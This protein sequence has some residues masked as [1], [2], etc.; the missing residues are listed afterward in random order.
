MSEIHDHTDELNELLFAAE[1]KLAE[2]GLGVSA[3]VELTP[4]C[5]LGFRKR[6]EIWHLVV[7]HD[8]IDINKY[9]PLM[10]MPRQYRVL[11][12][13]KLADLRD[14]LIAEHD[15]W[16]MEVRNATAAAR[17]FVDSFKTSG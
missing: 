13:T 1:D 3:F 14:A 7:R 2:M 5:R 9:E 16:V 12:A 15:K 10:Q 6:G 4:G 11:A 17:A 8:K